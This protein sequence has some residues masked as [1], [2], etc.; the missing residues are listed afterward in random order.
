MSTRETLLAAIATTLSGVASGRVYRSRREQM[1]TL[2]AVVVEPIEESGSEYVLGYC[3]R[4]L[5]VGV[6][7]FAKGDTPDNAADATLA[8]AWA[9][10]AA[11]PTLGL[12][13]GVQLDMEHAVDWDIEEIDH[14]RAVLRVTYSY[15]TATGSM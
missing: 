10:L 8:A 15:R 13:D 7:V 3:D 9:A 2:P 12:G 1:G 4:R 6:S 14:C 5:A 11:A